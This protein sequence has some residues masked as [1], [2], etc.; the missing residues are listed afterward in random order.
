MSKGLWVQPNT[1]YETRRIANA[2]HEFLDYGP[3]EEEDGW[4]RLFW[5]IYSEN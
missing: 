1:T 4:I 3:G 5:L 2:G